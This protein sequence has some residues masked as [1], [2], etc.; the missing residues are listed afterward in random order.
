MYISITKQLSKISRLKSKM[1]K[2]SFG[3]YGTMIHSVSQLF[4]K[5]VSMNNKPM[6]EKYLLACYNFYL[7]PTTKRLLL[8]I[9]DKFCFSALSQVKTKSLHIL[10]LLIDNFQELEYKRYFML[11][12]KPNYLMD[13]IYPVTNSTNFDGITANLINLRLELFKLDFKSVSEINVWTVLDNDEKYRL[14]LE[15]LFK[16]LQRFVLFLQHPIS[17]NQKYHQ[18]LMTY[19]CREYIR[20]I[21]AIL[22]LSKR[23]L[24]LENSSSE[25]L[26]YLM[27]IN[28]E[29]SQLFS[30]LKG[31]ITINTL[32][33]SFTLSSINNNLKNKKSLAAIGIENK[34]TSGTKNNIRYPA[35]DLMLEK[36]ENFNNS[37]R[38]STSVI[39][40]NPI[41]EKKKYYTKVGGINSSSFALSSEKN[42]QIESSTGPSSDEKLNNTSY[43]SNYQEIVK[44]DESIDTKSDPIINELV[45]QI[46]LAIEDY[47]INLNSK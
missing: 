16:N 35:R 46:S 20:L 3:T 34:E 8:A 39:P 42:F 47:K 2:A 7:N 13:E 5:T 11:N 12:K 40:V 19:V 25:T 28:Q 29:I 14:V 38:F 21:D 33:V 4:L 27:K 43:N 22:C 10:L 44:S 24:G 36:N 23:V 41:I 30:Y 32:P 17:Q 15:I 26:K 9:L 31:Y 37:R 18:S 6:K 1:K 45:D